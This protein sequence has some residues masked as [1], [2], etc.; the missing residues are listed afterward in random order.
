MKNKLFNITA[1]VLIFGTNVTSAAS[2]RVTIFTPMDGAIIS[3]KDA[4]K[5]NYEAD[6]GKS[7]DHLHLNV[8]GQLKEI[9]TN[10]KGTAQLSPLAPGKHKIC[11]A[12]STKGHSTT[13]TESC[14]NVIAE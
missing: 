10:L 6:A 8:D 7:G 2:G 4:I 14:L 3:T 12:V 11:L 13:G 1:L 9:I 5:L